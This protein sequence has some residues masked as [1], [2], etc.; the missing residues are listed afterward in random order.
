MKVNP[1]NEYKSINWDDFD[2]NRGRH[3]ATLRKDKE[4]SEKTTLVGQAEEEVMIF[5][6]SMTG[7]EDWIS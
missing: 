3:A 4:I 2:F 6:L 7:Y 1:Y 5:S